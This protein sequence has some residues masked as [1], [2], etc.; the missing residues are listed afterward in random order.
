MTHL[1]V[2][3]TLRHSST[4]ISDTDQD[5]SDQEEAQFL[6]EVTQ[7]QR[8]VCSIEQELTRAKLRENI[9]LGELYKFRAEEAECRLEMAE[10]ELGCMH[11]SM[12]NGTTALNDGPS[13]HKCR[14]TLLSSTF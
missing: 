12:R 4:G 5:G 14:H 9:V 8:H 6:L 13:D 11:N 1:L 7:A 10:F 3:I 2:F